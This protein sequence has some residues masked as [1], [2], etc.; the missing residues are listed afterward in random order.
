MEINW[1]VLGWIA[2]LL[3]VYIFGLLEGRNQGTKKRKAEEEQEKK[4]KPS[5]PEKPAAIPVDDPGILRIKN[6]SGSLTLDL[7]GA[8]L[9][10]SA[11]ASNHRK[12]LIEILNLIRPWLEGHPAPTSKTST[13]TPPPPQPE[14]VSVTQAP[15]MPQPAPVSA[16]AKPSIIPKEERPATPANS[17]VAQIDAILQARLAGTSLE[18][19]GVF[20]AQSPEGSVMVYVGLSRYAGIEAVPDEEIKVALRA[21]IAE[22]EKKYTPGL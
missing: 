2:G 22:L 6:E 1:S 14:A 15:S 8:R 12:R 3:F 7:D 16:P 20:L 10:T 9:D 19:R 11:L 17:I 18:E 13:M 4:D 21:A 5:T